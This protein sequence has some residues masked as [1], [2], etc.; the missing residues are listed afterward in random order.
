MDAVVS[1]RK[2]QHRSDQDRSADRLETLG[3]DDL[4]RT[5]AYWRAANYLS[6]GQIYLY[7]NPLLK[8]P[9]KLSHVKPLVVSHWGTTPGQNFIYVHLNRV[10]KKYDLD[11]IYIS[12][13]VTAARRLWATSTS[14]GPGARSIRPSRDRTAAV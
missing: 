7:D 3:S 4:R 5:N 14:K 12:G 13:P 9:L 2:P 1:V 10:I 6:V 11:M 8:D